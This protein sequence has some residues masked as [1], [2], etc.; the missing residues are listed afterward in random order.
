MPMYHCCELY[1]YSFNIKVLLCSDQL[2]N[3]YVSLCW[4]VVFRHMYLGPEEESWV[5][6]ASQDF[7]MGIGVVGRCTGWQVSPGKPAYALLLEQLQF[8]LFAV[9]D[10]VTSTAQIG[11]CAATLK[12]STTKLFFWFGHCL[13]KAEKTAPLSSALEKVKWVQQ[14][15]MKRN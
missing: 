1:F 10:F 11:C 6:Q 7:R 14:I 4:V 5:G 8:L 3:K 15:K 9:Y 2:K 12:R 13:I